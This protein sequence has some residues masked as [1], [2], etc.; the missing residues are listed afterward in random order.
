MMALAAV[1]VRELGLTERIWR[2]CRVDAERVNRGAL[3][4]GMVWMVIGA[5]VLICLPWIARLLPDPLPQI[6]AFDGDFMHG[7]AW[8]VVLLW[9]NSIMIRLMVLTRGRWSQ[10][11]RL[12]D[13][14]T[15]VIWIV[16]L[17]WWLTA[18]R[19]FLAAGTDAGARAGL[20]FVIVIIA[21]DLAWKLYR[22]RV[23]VPKL[24]A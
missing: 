24:P 4:L 1:G 9:L 22:Q 15:S 6:F 21:A 13:L 12:M 3:T 5:A 10:R 11:L 7:R 23:S 17:T 8:S 20:A 16:L 19:I 18:G 14:T 2:P